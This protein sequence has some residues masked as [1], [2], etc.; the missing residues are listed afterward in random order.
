MSLFHKVLF[1]GLQGGLHHVVEGYFGFWIHIVAPAYYAA[2]E[3]WFE[4]YLIQVQ[5]GS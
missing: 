2:S 1:C 3:S 5:A 4:H